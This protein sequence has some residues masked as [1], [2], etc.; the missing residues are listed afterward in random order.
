MKQHVERVFKRH[1]RAVKRAKWWGA[2]ASNLAAA[3]TGWH[4]WRPKAHVKR[5]SNAAKKMK[6][7]VEKMK[8]HVERVFKRHKRAVQRAKWWGAPAS[9][10]AAA[11]TGWHRWRPSIKAHFKRVSNAAKKMKQRVERAAK[12]AAKRA[13]AAANK[14]WTR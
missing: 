6:Q 5:G 2:P 9:N 10:L 13:K 7:H 14:H 11:K 3:K 1:K 8:Q 12:R 4:R